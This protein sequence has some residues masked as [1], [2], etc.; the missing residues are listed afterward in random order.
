MLLYKA[1]FTNYS[2][3]L[4]LRIKPKQD[5]N[6]IHFTRAKVFIVNFQTDSQYH[7]YKRIDTRVNNSES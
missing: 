3:S 4:S 1:S 5:T 6:N 7:T 2:L